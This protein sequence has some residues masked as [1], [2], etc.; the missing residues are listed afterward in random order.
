M[1]VTDEGHIA[2]STSLIADAEYILAWTEDGQRWKADV[3]ASDSVS[4]VA[5]VHIDSSAWPAVSLATNIPWN[6][7]QALALD[8]EDRSIS[9][10]EITSV[11][12]PLVEIDQPAALPGS[13]IVDDTGAVI[14]MVTADDTN[15][16]AIPSWMLE[17]VVVDLIAY[18]STTH[19]WLG[20]VVADTVSGDMVSV[21]QVVAGS[22]AALAGVREGDLIDSFNGDP[23]FDAASLHR[24]VQAAEPGAEAV[25]SV[26]R[27]ASRRLIVATLVELPS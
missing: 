12:S 17:Q 8:H 25:L 5:I 4:D 20:A 6:G 3:V 26:T 16:H 7:Q 22:P 1:F 21:E 10:G 19:V 18:G 15:R 2:T 13:A 14:A 24:R 11:S 27:N 9:L 23:V